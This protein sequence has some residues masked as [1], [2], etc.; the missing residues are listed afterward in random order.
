[1]GGRG[2]PAPAGGVARA[3]AQKH[4]E[5]T[6][7]AATT[8]RPPPHRGRLWRLSFC[9]CY[10]QEMV[11]FKS[12]WRRLKF[13]PFSACGGF[14]E[15]IRFFIQ[16]RVSEPTRWAWGL[17]RG[18][19]RSSVERGRGGGLLKELPIAVR[20]PRSRQ[21]APAAAPERQRGSVRC[22]KTRVGRRGV[23]RAL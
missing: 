11:L 16:P 2:L 21:P 8:P 20:F 3:P 19:G 12:S 15:T 23:S 4:R 1:M 18:G 14:P 7:G 17:L 6:Q 9:L 13:S 22:G 5:V 10:S